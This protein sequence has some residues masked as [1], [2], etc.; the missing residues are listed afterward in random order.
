MHALDLY[1]SRTHSEVK[2]ADGK[3]YK[4]PNEFTV[5]EVERVL[6]LEIERN[7]LEKM[8]AEDVKNLTP[9]NAEFKR[10]MGIVFS[11]LTILFQHYQ[12]E[13]TT[14][15][16][17]S[18]MTQK[19]A[20]GMLGFFQKYRHI[21]IKEYLAEKNKDQSTEADSKKKLSPRTEL[22]DLR[23]L[24]TFMVVRGFSLFEVRRLYVDE[25]HAFYEQLVYNLEKM[26][27]VKEGSYA[28]IIQGKKGGKVDSVSQL[29][30]QMMIGL[31]GR[32][33]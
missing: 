12:P 11:Q 25:L 9:E 1:K 26:G 24:I 2:L 22:R 17:K 8:Q 7:A 27:E 33:K 5:E 29:R 13:I 6:E 19:E 3:T 20:L 28:K 31:A 10:Y 4:T 21:A 16:L 14:E 23:R 18:V 15:Y 32:K 30:K